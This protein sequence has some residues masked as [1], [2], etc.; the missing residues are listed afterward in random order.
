M[1]RWIFLQICFSSGESL[2][3]VDKISV[4]VWK[5]WEDNYGQLKG[6]SADGNTYMTL[7]PIVAITWL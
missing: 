3:L 6:V 7:I 4:A 1:P 5:F 2:V